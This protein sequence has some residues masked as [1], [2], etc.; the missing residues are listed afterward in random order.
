MSADTGHVGA[1]I[2][3][4]PETEL[5]GGEVPLDNLSDDTNDTVRELDKLRR[6]S[7]RTV[8]HEG[9]LAGRA[10]PRVHR[11]ADVALEVRPR[12]CRFA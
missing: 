7:V 4:F 10:S 11:L 2:M 5:L 3:L 12:A 8:R 6:A 1:R 9:T